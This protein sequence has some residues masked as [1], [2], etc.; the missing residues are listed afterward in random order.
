MKRVILES[1]FAPNLAHDWAKKA[2]ASQAEYDAAFRLELEINKRYARAACHD[3]LVNHGETPMASHLLYT[4]EGI[5]DDTIPEE[6]QLGIDAGLAW[7][8]VTGK[9][10]VYLDRG[11]S[12]GMVY[13]IRKALEDGKPVECRFLAAETMTALGL[14]AILVDRDRLKD[15]GLVIDGIAA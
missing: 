4:Q 1:P 11:L 15:I 9:T 6:R 3:C 14:P 10:V 8:E 7:R 2:Y 5:L 13:G 12:G